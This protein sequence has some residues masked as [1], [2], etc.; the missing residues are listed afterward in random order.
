M[1]RGTKQRRRNIVFYFRSVHMPSGETA[2]ALPQTCPG[3]PLPNRVQ[4]ELT[5]MCPA[6]P[7][8]LDWVKGHNMKESTLPGSPAL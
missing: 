4:T 6:S 8:L 7:V 2:C 3:T 1:N 5:G